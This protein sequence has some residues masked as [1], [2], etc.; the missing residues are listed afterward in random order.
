MSGRYEK[1]YPADSDPVW[2][3]MT[4]DGVVNNLARFYVSPAL[5]VRDLREG[6]VVSTPYAEYRFVPDAPSATEP[7]L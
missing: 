5:C 2:F 7:T 3:P 4:E 6:H 1:R